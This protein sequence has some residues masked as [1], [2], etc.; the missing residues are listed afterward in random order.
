MHL[1]LFRN[2]FVD[3]TSATTQRKALLIKEVLDWRAVLLDQPLRSPHQSTLRKGS[4]MAHDTPK[5]EF[6][7]F[8]SYHPT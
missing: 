8:V 7:L 5:S 1:R 4:A 2:F 3:S 6:D